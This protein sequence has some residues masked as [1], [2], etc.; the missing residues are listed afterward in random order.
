MRYH[1][2]AAV[3]RKRKIAFFGIVALVGVVVLGVSVAGAHQ[4]RPGP[5]RPTT[6]VEAT[7]T[8]APEPENPAPEEPPAEEETDPAEPPAEEEEHSNHG[9]L[10]A[11]DYIDIAQVAPAPRAPRPGRNASRG[12]FTSRCGTNA[13]GH[14]DSSNFIVSPGVANGAHH[15]HDYVGSLDAGQNSTNESLAAS[16]TTCTNGDRSTYF[17]PVLRDLTQDGDDVDQAGGG[18]DGNLGR[19]LRPVFA[20]IQFRGNAQSRVVAMP[21]FL[22]VITGDAKAVANGGEAAPNRRAQWT[23]SGSQNRIST[24]LY[25]VCPAGQ[26]VIRIAD[27]PGCWDGQNID[28]A[29]HRTHTAFADPQTGACPAGFRAIPQLRITLGYRVPPGPL[30]F[31]V[32]TFPLEGQ[33]KAI[34]DHNDFVNVMSTRLMNRA[35][36]CINRGSRC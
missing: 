27:F 2:T 5:T 20:N 30:T 34:T 6:P 24:T 29:N 22:R 19:I 12:T 15:F 13:N 9:P 35:V 31:A 8:E 23:C 36:T 17:W 11:A 10:T 26:L 4:G 7:P 21:R 25:T 14:R 32:D 18:Q 16:G 33:R 28:S 1:R 3:V